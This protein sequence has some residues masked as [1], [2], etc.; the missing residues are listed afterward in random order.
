MT[1]TKRARERERNEPTVPVQH[2]PCTTPCSVPPGARVQKSKNNDHADAS[3]MW[4]AGAC[5]KIPPPAVSPAQTLPG[6]L[7][8][9]WVL[10]VS[11]STSAA[12]AHGSAWRGRARVRARAPPFSGSFPSLPLERPLL[13]TQHAPSSL[14]LTQRRPHCWT[15]VPGGPAPPQT[16]ARRAPPSPPP[17]RPTPPPSG[18]PGGAQWAPDHGPRAGPRERCGP[19][20]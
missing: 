15:R 6:T 4:A 9:P 12:C 19:P 10:S 18:R 1:G 17:P 3:P 8:G 20:T 7:R 16:G 11:Q 2:H 5:S 13:L 14:V